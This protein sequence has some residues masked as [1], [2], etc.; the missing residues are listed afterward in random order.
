MKLPTILLLPTRTDSVPI[1]VGK[2]KSS[3]LHITQLIPD[4]ELQKSITPKFDGLKSQN[5]RT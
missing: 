1:K 5:F 2:H 3:E 4:S